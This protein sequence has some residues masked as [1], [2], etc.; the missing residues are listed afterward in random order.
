M[1][2]ICTYTNYLFRAC[3]DLLIYFLETTS[4]TCL[5]NVL[6][7][8][9]AFGGQFYDDSINQPANIN[10]VKIIGRRPMQEEAACYH[11]N[12]THYHPW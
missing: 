4:R 7:K 9:T 11:S 2:F 1:Q 6:N 10:S 5:Q 8:T 3:L 12:P